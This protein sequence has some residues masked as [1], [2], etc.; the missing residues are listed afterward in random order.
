MKCELFVATEKGP[1]L[2]A[3]I[4]YENGRISGQLQGGQGYDLLFASVLADPITVRGKKI[5]P[6]DDPAAW[7]NGLPVAYNGSHFW[8]Q[9]SEP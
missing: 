1:R 4:F 2:V 8:A 9:M 5:S 3:T 6:A 7:F